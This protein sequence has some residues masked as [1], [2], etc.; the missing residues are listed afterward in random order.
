MTSPILWLLAITVYVVHVVGVTADE[1]TNQSLLHKFS[2]RTN[3]QLRKLVTICQ[4]NDQAELL[5]QQGHSTDQ[6]LV[7][8]EL[9]KL[10]TQLTTLTQS[11]ELL[12]Q[13]NN[14]MQHTINTLNAAPRLAETVNVGCTTS[15]RDSCT[16]LCTSAYILTNPVCRDVFN[17][18]QTTRITMELPWQAVCYPANGSLDCTGTCVRASVA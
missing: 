9:T 7:Y 17:N 2:K 3:R 5:Q 10:T 6:T 11:V 8:E 18:I 13:V 14:E 12:R 15:T 16:L 4:A 1:Q